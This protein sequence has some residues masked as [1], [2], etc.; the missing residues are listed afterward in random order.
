MRENIRQVVRESFDTD[1]DIRGPL[2]V[3]LGPDSRLS[4][5]DIFLGSPDISIR[6][7]VHLDSLEINPEFWALLKGDIH[8]T[9]LTASGFSVDYCPAWLPG[10]APRQQRVDLPSLAVNKLR[11]QDIHL[12]CG[13]AEKQPGL[14]FD[15]FD[16]E[17]SASQ[18]DAIEIS[19]LGVVNEEPFEL[20]VTAGSLDSLLGNPARFPLALT[21]QLLSSNLSIDGSIESPMSEPSLDATASLNIE[22]LARLLGA[23]G[24][25]RMPLERLKFNAHLQ[26]KWEEIVL[27]QAQATLDDM[28][29]TFSGLAKGFSERPY[30]EISMQLD[31]LDSSLPGFTDQDDA[32][33]R[34]SWKEISFKPWF[35]EMKLFDADIH[36]GV[37]QILNMP[38]SGE[39][40]Y[41]SAELDKGELI[42]DQLELL[43]AGSPFHAE[44]S[45]NLNVDCPAL[46]A[47]LGISTV[48][49]SVL[50]P[51]IDGKLNIGGQLEQL[52][53]NTTGCGESLS[54]FA[55]N[56]SAVATLTN[57]NP[58]FQNIALSVTADTLS[59]EFGSQERGKL[60][61]EGKLEGEQLSIEI[62]FAAL[63]DVLAGSSWPLI[64]KAD[65][66]GGNVLL[67]GMAA[68][69]E[70]QPSLDGNLTAE[71]YS[72]GASTSLIGVDPDYS[73]DME[74]DTQISFDQA[75][76]S[77]T[78]L[79][80]NLGHSNLA[81]GFS[82]SPGEKS[83]TIITN[84]HSKYIDL[85]ELSRLLPPSGEPEIT[86]DFDWLTDLD[87][88]EK[89]FALPSVKFDFVAEKVRGFNFDL[90]Q[91][92]M[93]GNVSDG[94]IDNARVKLKFEEIEIEGRLHADLRQEH[95][96]LEYESEAI[97]V[98]IANLLSKFDFEIDD[99]IKANRLVSELTSEGQSIQELVTNVRY[100]SRI[101]DFHWSRKVPFGTNTDELFLSYLETIMGPSITTSWSG[102]GDLNGVPVN[103]LMQTPS[104]PETLD[105]NKPLPFNLILGSEDHVI[106]IDAV[107]SQRT[108]TNPLVE[109]TVSG[110]ER[111]TLDVPLSQ[112]QSPLK[113]YELHSHITTSN[114]ELHF[115]EIE[116]RLGKSI[117]RGRIDVSLI[118][119][120]N[121][122]NIAVTSPYIETND[123]IPLIQ[124]LRAIDGAS[125]SDSP[126]TQDLESL[127]ALVNQKIDDLFITHAFD[128]RL[129]I[130]QLWS[131]GNLLGKAQFGLR[132]IG[133]ELYIEPIDLTSTTSGTVDAEYYRKRTSDGLEVGLDVQIEG[134]EYSGISRLL[135]S[136]SDGSGLL[137]LDMSLFTEGS[138]LEELPVAW[139][140]EINLAIFPESIPADILDVWASNL[141]FALLPKLPGTGENKKINCLV[142]RFNSENSVLRSRKL[143]LDTTDI[144]VHGRGSIDLVNQE[145]D[146]LFSPQAKLEKF[147]SVSAPIRVEGPFNNFKIG[148]TQ[149]GFIMTLFRWYMG[150]IY[151][152]YKRL[153]GEKFPAD[154]IA[155][156]YNAM[157]WEMP[158]P[159]EN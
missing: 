117:A 31:K 18:G 89:W 107:I 124:K 78:G 69:I 122:F 16:L 13:R 116:A 56:F 76:L 99:K 110:Q 156:C 112:L 53:I 26:V 127:L 48:D 120:K 111:E 100:K 86:S 32:A 102:E 23:F 146:L 152:P 21:L 59:V 77:L 151:V 8:L 12:H 49:L 88:V 33:T 87:R 37:T 131:N 85:E 67:N 137:Y 38:L 80:V 75:E 11:I 29:L 153:T 65:G 158:V 133:D 50:N 128:A 83:S 68:I 140:G 108:K 82:W 61:F 7:L 126:E 144:L 22:N 9:S 71:I 25:D 20:H 43:L 73:L 139:E 136:E 35:D 81:G 47:E 46:N 51:L 79:D 98:D 129:D 159:T 93:T 130:E 134:L 42:V 101:E 6:R 148:V 45:L 41:L 34:D 44:A 105:R 5:S 92:V 66:T 106:M 54:E 125:T 58:D 91:L 157:D 119:E 3:H 52:L 27:E 135:N 113:A 84:L 10:K 142:A 90:D 57:I 2:R 70:G 55:D 123:F 63:N 36:I 147:L 95:W 94:L 154:G 118:D 19:I 141:I 62:T 30:L 4:V 143:L 155:T 149:G 132:L 115:S 14:I 145:L 150:L 104:V 97:N 40:F 121:H 24:I 1:I 96:T 72:V 114:G 39:A 74:V 60:N 17:G 28:Q 109:I 138:V 64:L 103:L 15:P